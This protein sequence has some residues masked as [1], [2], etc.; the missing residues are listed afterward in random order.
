M[1]QASEAPTLL[2]IS[3]VVPYPPAA[4]NEI[5]ILK[6]I[7]WMKALGFRIILL[8]NHS[9]LPIDRKEALERIVDKVHFIGDDYG[10]L[11]PVADERHPC[12][13][14]KA[15]LAQVLPDSPLYRVL[16]G[17]EKQKKINSD[18]VKRYLASEHLV[19]VT[20]HLAGLYQPQVVLVEYIFAAPC[21]SWY[22]AQP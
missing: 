12:T 13:K 21:P 11:A 14:L 16:F 15:L 8:L 6:M 17:M 3:H 5:R 20:S 10:I 2:L 1:R 19:Q 7:N 22:L 4:G 9:P 18:N